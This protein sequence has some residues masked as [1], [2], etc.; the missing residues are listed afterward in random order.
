MVAGTTSR[1]LGGHEVLG[2]QLLGREFQRGRHHQEGR[3]DVEHRLAVKPGLAR[4]GGAR[5][6]QIGDI[7]RRARAGQ[8]AVA[9]MEQRLAI[10]HGRIGGE[11]APDHIGFQGGR[12]RAKERRH[13]GEGVEIV[14]DQHLAGDPDHLAVGL[15]PV[16]LLG[17][18]DG[19]ALELAGLVHLLELRGFAELQALH[20]LEVGNRRAP[21]RSPGRSGVL[22]HRPPAASGW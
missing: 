18:A 9:G 1:G 14:I 2:Q 19:A 21:A 10:G 13:P 12:G 4:H 17:L 8:V 15:D 22:P 11:D 7:E 20:R 3:A 5:L 6:G 16:G